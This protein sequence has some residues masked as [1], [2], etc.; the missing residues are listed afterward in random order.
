VIVQKSARER[1]REN[2]KSDGRERRA[3]LSSSPKQKKG[4]LC[5]CEIMYLSR[6]L[7]VPRLD[8]QRA[9]KTFFQIVCEGERWKIV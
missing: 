8:S 7:A 1:K 4:A 5:E 6:L 2:K 3:Q 9:I